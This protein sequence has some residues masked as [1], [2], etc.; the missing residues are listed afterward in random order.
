M[1]SN[2]D[3]FNYPSIIHFKKFLFLSFHYGYFTKKCADFIRT[4]QQ[5]FDILSQYFDELTIKYHQNPVSLTLLFTRKIRQLMNNTTQK[6]LEQLNLS[7]HLKILLL[8]K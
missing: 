6:K 1:G 3:P 4:Q 2:H 7:E 8:L 5:L